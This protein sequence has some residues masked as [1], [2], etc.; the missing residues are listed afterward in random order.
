MLVGAPLTRRA[1]AMSAAAAGRCGAARARSGM[2]VLGNGGGVG[3]R[4]A[5]H[6]WAYSTFLEAVET[7]QIEGLLAHG[8]QVLSIDKDGNRHEC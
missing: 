2:A 3:R 4:A 6:P 7:H 5:P 1:P 8:K